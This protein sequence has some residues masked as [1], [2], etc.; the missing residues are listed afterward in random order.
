[1]LCGQGVVAIWN[2]ITDAG[3]AEFYAWHVGEHMPERIAIPGF[4]RG[5]RYR[6]IDRQTRPEFFTLYELETFSVTTS[7]DYLGRLNAPTPWTKKATAAFRNTSRGLG[8]VLA[9]IGPGPGGVLAT[10]R[11]GLASDSNQTAQS[12]LID[13]MRKVAQLPMVTGAHLVATDAEASAVKTAESKDRTD[14]QAPPNWFAMV[15]ACTAASLE[16]PIRNLSE[17]GFVQNPDVGRYCLESTRL[18]TDQAPG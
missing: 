2:D 4:L 12:A 9:S 17:S 3:R 5:R 16:A 11:F 6:A 14:I 7:Q 15:E 8:R 1:M 10:I 13:L 18:K